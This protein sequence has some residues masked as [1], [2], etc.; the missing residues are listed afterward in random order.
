[1]SVTHR[2]GST[3]WRTAEEFATALSWAY[4]DEFAPTTVTLFSERDDEITTHWITIDIAHAVSLA[5][6]A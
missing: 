3:P 4:D 6:M 2:T 1:M 5:D